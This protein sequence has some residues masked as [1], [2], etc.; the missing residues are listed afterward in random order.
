MAEL[1]KELGLVL[2]VIIG[3]HTYLPKSSSAEAPQDEI[4]SRE[5]NE[6][7][8]SR[9]EELRDACR[10][11]GDSVAIELLGRRELGDEALLEEEGGVEIRQ[12]GELA[13]RPAVGDQQIQAEVDDTDDPMD[14]ET[15]R[16]LRL[17]SHATGDRPSPFSTAWDTHP[18]ACWTP[19][20]GNVV[21]SRMGRTSKQVRFLGQQRRC[22][23]VNATAALRMLL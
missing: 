5:R 1:E 9:P 11:A 3:S 21:P 7:T 14:K 16:L 4:Q 6:T 15:R 8:G 19:N 23:D 10:C 13:G 12:Q 2:G 22:A 20:K 18:V 17:S